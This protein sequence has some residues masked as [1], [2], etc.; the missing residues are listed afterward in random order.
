VCALSF[1]Q[2]FFNGGGPLVLLDGYQGQGRALVVAAGCS[3]NPVYVG[4]G[5][6]REVKVDDVGDELENYGTFIMK[7]TVAILF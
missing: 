5:V 2:V 3:T 1:L 6:V 4:V 7:C